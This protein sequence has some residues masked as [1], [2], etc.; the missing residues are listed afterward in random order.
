MAF[1]P[2]IT[3]PDVS[4]AALQACRLAGKYLLNVLASVG[5]DPESIAT[6]TDAL[7]Q[8]W[9]APWAYDA[10]CAWHSCRIALRSAGWDVADIAVDR[11]TE[12]RTTSTYTETPL[13]DDS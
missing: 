1:E 4:E 3:D 12:W 8:V 10:W 6:Q 13:E 9:P 5:V 11:R 2:R 7:D